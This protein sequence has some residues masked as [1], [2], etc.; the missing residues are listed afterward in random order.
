M[1]GAREL[2]TAMAESNERTS[3]TIGLRLAEAVTA[4]E[5]ATGYLQT[6]LRSS[7]ERALASAA[8]YLRLFGLVAGGAGLARGA[9]AVIAHH[10]QAN[11]D[12]HVRLALYFAENHLP[13]SE[14]LRNVVE[15]GPDSLLTT[16]PDMLAV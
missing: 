3:S 1:A 13:L 5:D 10:P 8:P 14:G 2:A 12:L 6:W 15:R 9:R 16:T 11:D 7:D 4:L